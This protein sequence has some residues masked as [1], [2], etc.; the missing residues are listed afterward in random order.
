MKFKY[1]EKVKI[2]TGDFYKGAIGEVIGTSESFLNMFPSYTVLL[3]YG[4]KLVYDKD[5]LEKFNED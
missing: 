2:I 5:S 4:Q 1:G 3:K